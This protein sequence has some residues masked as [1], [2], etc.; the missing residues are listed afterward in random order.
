MSG[1]SVAQCESY[2]EDNVE[3]GRL[4]AETGLHDGLQDLPLLSFSSILQFIPERFTGSQNALKHYML[5]RPRQSLC[6]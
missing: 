5:S 3:E 4:D 2:P 1:H 6:H